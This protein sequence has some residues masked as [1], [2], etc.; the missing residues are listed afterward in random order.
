[1]RLFFALELRL[2]FNSPT[3][4]IC[5]THSPLR[6]L[7]FPSAILKSHQILPHPLRPNQQSRLFHPSILTV[8]TTTTNPNATFFFP[9]LLFLFH[10]TGIRNK[11][12]IRRLAAREVLAAIIRWT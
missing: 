3:V 9:S 5:I 6:L 10:H 8:H 1:M 11:S 4:S 2:L 7:I 12:Q